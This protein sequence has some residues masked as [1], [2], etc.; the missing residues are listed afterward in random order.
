VII[1]ICPG[2]KRLRH[3]EQPL[4]VNGKCFKI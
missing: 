3:Q 4:I 1:L 2:I